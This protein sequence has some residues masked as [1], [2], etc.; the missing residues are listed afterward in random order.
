[1]INDFNKEEFD[2][3]IDKLCEI[4]NPNYIFLASCEEMAEKMREFDPSQEIYV[5]PQSIKTNNN[6]NDAIWV[7]PTDNKPVRFIF[8]DK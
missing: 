1:M 7:V 6:N 5:V 2:K 8:E 3:I 4:G